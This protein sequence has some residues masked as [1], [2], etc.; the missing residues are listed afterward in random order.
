MLKEKIWNKTHQIDNSV[1][2]GGENF[3]GRREEMVTG[4]SR[5]K[6][7]IKSEFFYKNTLAII[8]I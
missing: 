6:Y 7:V 2:L 8:T 3:E 5:D 1:I 4:I